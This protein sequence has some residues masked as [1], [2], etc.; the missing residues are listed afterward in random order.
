MGISVV[1]T[2]GKGGVGKSTATVGLGRALTKLHRR[3]LMIDCDA[4]LRTLD[5]LTG[6]EKNLVFDISDVIHGRCA[7]I[8][9]IYT[10]GQSNNLFVIPGASA[11][12]GIIRP[13][14]MKK[15][16]EMLKRYYD[17]I[18]LDSPAGVGRG[19]T[20]AACAADRA[21][22]VCNPDPVSVRSAGIV[23]E[24]LEE[25]GISERHLLI[26][27]FSDDF[28]DTIASYEDLDKVIDNAGI[29]LLGVVPEDYNLA[30][31]FLNGREANETGE[32]MMAF[33]RVASRLEGEMIPILM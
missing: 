21:V 17:Y 23:R 26:N 14:V 27:R 11:P 7:P 18:L 6:I 8:D 12:K 32:G 15:F 20:S 28:F 16:I 25:L 31:S 19:F 5:K 30:A 9:A 10:C 24:A 33:S 13:E 22:V 1:V 4:G 3:V 2:S 29:K